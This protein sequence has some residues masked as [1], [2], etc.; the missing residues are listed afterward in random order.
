MKNLKIKITKLAAAI[1][2]LFSATSSAGIVDYIA[3]YQANALGAERIKIMSECEN[4]LGESL[5]DNDRA[6]AHL[7]SHFATRDFENLETAKDVKSAI[8]RA[9]TLDYLAFEKMEK[10]NSDLETAGRSGLQHLVDLQHEIYYK[11]QDELIT[12]HKALEANPQ[13]SAGYKQ[14]RAEMMSEFYRFS[15]A[16]CRN[17]DFWYS[18]TKS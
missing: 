4:A 10:A 11:T 9:Q 7:V 1:S 14:V 18:I 15:S 8:A 17:V 2:I 6:A 3:H 12:Y 16:D 13:G 5:T